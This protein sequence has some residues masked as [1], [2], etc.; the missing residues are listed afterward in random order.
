MGKIKLRDCEELINIINKSSQDKIF[1]YKLINNDEFF[2]G[3]RHHKLQIYK[4]GALLLTIS[5]DRKKLLKYS[6]PKHNLPLNNIDKNDISLNINEVK[7]NFETI[8]SNAQ[9]I[10]RKETQYEKICQQW[11][12]TQNN[13]KSD[14][15]YFIDMEYAHQGEHMGRFDLIAISKKP[16]KEKHKVCII[17]LKIGTQ[18]YGG[19]DDK[20]SSNSGIIGHLKD[21]IKFLSDEKYYFQLSK[22]IISIIKCYKMLKILP[23]NSLI[24]NN[25]GNLFEKPEILFVTYSNCPKEAIKDINIKNNEDI[26]CMKNKLYDCLF[27]YSNNLETSFPIEK[28]SSFLELKKQDFSLLN[29]ILVKQSIKNE[30]YNFTFSFINADNDF[31]WDILRDIP[32][33]S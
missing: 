18:S 30:L 14:D 25:L 16:F 17:E 4:D 24:I 22:N 11:I 10:Y 12:V 13:L 2:C 19:S 28:I 26:L 27:K 33:E 15:W 5:K 6:T 31:C 29:H 9:N 3:I 1:I 21:F 23:E 8:V 20:K 7:K 32:F